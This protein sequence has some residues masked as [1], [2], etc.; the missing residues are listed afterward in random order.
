MEDMSTQAE[1]LKQGAYVITLTTPLN[2]THFQLVSPGRDMYVGWYGS[3]KINQN[4]T[5]ELSV[6]CFISLSLFL[7]EYYM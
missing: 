5:H 7:N 3:L 6:N 4:K 2:S 1:Q